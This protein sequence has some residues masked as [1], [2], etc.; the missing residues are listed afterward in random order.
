MG[1][2]IDYLL[3]NKDIL[4]LAFLLVIVFREPIGKLIPEIVRAKFGIK[5]E[6]TPPGKKDEWACV[7]DEFWHEA[8][9]KDM[10]S[11]QMPY[12]D[13]AYCRLILDTIEQCRQQRKRLTFNFIQVEAVSR[14]ALS[15][16]RMAW[17]DIRDHN[18]VYLSFVFPQK[19][20]DLLVDLYEFM[21]GSLAEKPTPFIQLR[22]D[23]RRK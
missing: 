6:E 22:I 16:W 13:S 19:K 2:I 21:S 3:L 8:E 20:V 4:S 10:L 17:K 18:H 5:K 9:V 11:L 7:P 14:H 1:E 12:D 23:E 15:G